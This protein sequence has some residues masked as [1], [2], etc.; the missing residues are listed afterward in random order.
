MSLDTHSG[1]LGLSGSVISCG[2]GS[3]NVENDGGSEF[4]SLNSI[5]FV[6]SAFF[7]TQETVFSLSSFFFFHNK[8]KIINIHV[9]TLSMFLLNKLFMVLLK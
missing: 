5:F 7:I 8:K 2:F 4:C 6:F 9:L 3:R 1:H